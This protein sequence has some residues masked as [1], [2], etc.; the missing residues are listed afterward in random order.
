MHQIGLKLWS[1]NENYFNKAKRL[2]EE[3]FYEYIEL[4]AV[5]DSLE[6]V[7]LWKKLR[8]PYIVHAP[9][10]GSGLNLADN[11]KKS[12]NLRLAAQAIRFADE[13][14]AEY[15]IFQLILIYIN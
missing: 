11:E 5:P 8:V 9:H 2:F 10:Y 7:D 15:I 1:T 12:N 3:G 14:S 4:Y 13:L 6:F